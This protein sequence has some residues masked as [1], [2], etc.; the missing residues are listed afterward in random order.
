MVIKTQKAF[1][2]VELIF[3]I[4]IIGILSAI[5]VPK[6]SQTAELAY[7]SKAESVVATLRS[8]IATERQKRILRGVTPLA[9]ITNTEAVA[10]LAYGIDN[11][12]STTGTNQFT[13]T[14]PGGTDRCIFQISGGTLT[15][16]ATCDSHTGLTGL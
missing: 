8:V 5:A 14:V 6:F 7:V 16:T 12:W 10:L 2:M 13:Y 9:E 15:R 1:T 11:S 3:V 4:I